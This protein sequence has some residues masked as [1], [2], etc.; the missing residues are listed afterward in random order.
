MDQLTLPDLDRRSLVG[1]LMRRQFAGL[2]PDDTLR[3]A[4]EV[5]RLSR[6]RHLPVLQGGILV[7]LLSYRDVLEACLPPAAD[8]LDRTLRGLDAMLVGDVMRTR[9]FAVTP[10]RTLTEAAIAMIRL[11]LGC[12]PVI[13]P[14]HEGP[15]LVGILTE[16]DL[17]RAAYSP[18]PPDPTA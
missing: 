16:S 3:E 15:R 1:A 2:A 18:G 11:R 9:P 17:L 14:T 13:E 4:S 12:L 8:E 7:G 5:M 10:E 6:V